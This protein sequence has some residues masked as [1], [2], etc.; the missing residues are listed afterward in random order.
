MPSKIENINS[1]IPLLATLGTNL[2]VQ[3]PL[4]DTHIWSLRVNKMIDVYLLVFRV[5]SL[6]SSHLNLL[7]AWSDLNLG[8]G[9]LRS[10][11]YAYHS[12]SLNVT[13]PHSLNN[14]FGSLLRLQGIRQF[15]D[16]CYMWREPLTKLL[17]YSLHL[18]FESICVCYVLFKKLSQE[19]SQYDIFLFVVVRGGLGNL[20]L[21]PLHIYL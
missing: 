1:L 2:S 17:Y 5:F 19:G 4:R 10:A 11:S 8:L 18:L 12:M 13:Q 9:L 14:R 7:L 20:Y 21:L 16:P 3:E 6:V 15:T